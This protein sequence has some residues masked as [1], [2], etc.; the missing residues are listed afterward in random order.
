MRTY[1]FDATS[2][3]LTASLSCGWRRWII[4]RDTAITMSYQLIK[5]SEI[6]LGP[7]THLCPL[8][9]CGTCRA[10]AGAATMHFQSG[11]VHML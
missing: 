2:S 10:A 9:F 5:I 4:G 8:P 11:T 1:L 3:C 7:Y 6:A